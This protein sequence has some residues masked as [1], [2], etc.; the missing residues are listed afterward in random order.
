LHKATSTL[1]TIET[2]MGSSRHSLK[3]ERIVIRQVGQGIGREATANYA[4]GLWD[5]FPDLSFVGEIE[6]Y[7]QVKSDRLKQQWTVAKFCEQDTGKNVEDLDPT[8]P[9]ARRKDTS[10]FEKNALF[11]PGQRC[12]FIGCSDL[13]SVTPPEPVVGSQPE[14]SYWRPPGTSNLR[15]HEH[16]R[17]TN[18]P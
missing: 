11:P 17:M 10:I 2:P 3:A 14:L 18:S 15:P 9:P 4:R 12:D 1:G 6:Q 7:V 8:G 13:P 16:K 5:A